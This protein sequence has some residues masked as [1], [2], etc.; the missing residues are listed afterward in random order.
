MRR[1]L[2]ARRGE[3]CQQFTDHEVQ[4][5][6]GLAGYPMLCS[7][8]CPHSSAE[9]CPRKVSVCQGNTSLWKHAENL[10]ADVL[11]LWQPVL[12]VTPLMVTSWVRQE[13]DGRPPV[14]KAPFGWFSTEDF[15]FFP[16]V[17]H[18]SSSWTLIMTNFI[19]NVLQNLC[20]YLY[21]Q[22]SVTSNE[23]F[24]TRPTFHQAT[25]TSAWVWLHFS[26]SW[27]PLRLSPYRVHIPTRLTC[28]YATDKMDF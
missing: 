9:F 4:V 18:S 21:Q 27:I 10:D 8:S 26:L 20:I 23:M 12:F 17:F 7:S 24:L 1:Y 6:G 13:D 14:S 28:T 2:V 11:I 22:K 3:W 25:L 5:R 16:S 19:W 15:F